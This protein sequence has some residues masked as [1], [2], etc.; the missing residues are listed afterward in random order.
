MH[1]ARVPVER[2]R[3]RGLRP[4][5]RQLRLRLPPRLLQ[6]LAG[7]PEAHAAAAA[8]EQAEADEGGLVHD[9]DEGPRV[10]ERFS[11]HQAGEENRMRRSMHHLQA[12]LRFLQ[13]SRE[14]ENLLEWREMS[15]L[16]GIYEL[17][18]RARHL[19]QVYKTRY[20]VSLQNFMYYQTKVV[21]PGIAPFSRLY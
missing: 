4:F 2:R 12:S 11:N 8:G 21:A 5:G 15:L 13:T 19:S 18:R 10:F 16:Q 6:V 1:L 3:L 14:D 7:E 9:V 17:C 20:F